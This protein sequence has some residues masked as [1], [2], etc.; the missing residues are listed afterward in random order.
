MED[1]KDNTWVEKL[2]EFIRTPDVSL[3]NFPGIPLQ[4][5]GKSGEQFSQNP[6]YER[7]VCLYRRY[8]YSSQPGARG[9]WLVTEH[10]TPVTASHRIVKSIQ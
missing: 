5:T 8:I 1:G 4:A 6:G 3:L 9:A 10:I 2:I 7:P